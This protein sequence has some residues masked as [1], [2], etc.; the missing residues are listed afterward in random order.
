M[1]EALS[2][3][4]LGESYVG[5]QVL[6][7]PPTPADA[8]GDHWLGSVTYAGK[9]VCR[10]GLRERELPQHVAI[11]GRSGA[12]KT[13]SAYLLVA[14]L[15]RAGIPFIVLDW[16]RNEQSVREQGFT[17]ELLTREAL[18]WLGRRDR[19]RPFLLVMSYLTPHPPLQAP[20]EL[21][22]L[23]ERGQEAPMEPWLAAQQGLAAA[24]R[25]DLRHAF[26]RRGALRLAEV[27]RFEAWSSARSFE[28]ELRGGLEPSR[29]GK[30]G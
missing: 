24:T 27:A 6:L 18:A 1:A 25:A 13:N 10:F 23:L 21:I 15:L 30:V 22:A 3:E 28:L 26:H 4:L 17:T 29:D 7:E 8:A 11:L 9:P 20:P 5:E 12:G 14:N 2:A 19:D 16:R